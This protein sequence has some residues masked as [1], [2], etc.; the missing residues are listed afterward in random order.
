MTMEM[1]LEE[2]LARALCVA[3][4]D[5]PE[6]RI[7]E[8]GRSSHSYPAWEDHRKQAR[9]VIEATRIHL[10]EEKTAYDRGDGTSFGDGYHFAW[11]EVA[12]LIGLPKDTFTREDD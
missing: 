1:S 11:E 12:E 5:Q 10:R 4:G 3:A 8:Y 2:R 7:Q 9:S 6:R